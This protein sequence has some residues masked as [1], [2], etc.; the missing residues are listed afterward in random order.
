MRRNFL[1][2]IVLLF[3][4]LTGCSSTNLNELDETLSA[5]TNPFPPSHRSPIV[6]ATIVKTEAVKPTIKPSPTPTPVPTSSLGVDVS[7]L[8]GQQVQFWHPWQGEMEAAI[9]ELVEEFN[10][11][12]EWGIQVQVHSTG[13]LDKLDADLQVAIQE[14]KQPDL[15]VAYL[16]QALGWAETPIDLDVYLNDSDWGLSK[17]D[18]TDFFSVFWEHARQ[19]EQMLGLPAFASAQVLYYNQ[20]WAQELGFDSPPDTIEELE[21]QVCA[22]AKANLQDED[23]EN[24]GSGGLLLTSNYS[25]ML[26]WMTAFGAQITRDVSSKEDSPYQFNSPEV[27]NAFT[28]LRDLHDQGC[29]SLIEE[30]DP[31][32]LFAARS[33][34]LI[35][36]SVASMA[37]QIAAMKRSNNADN[38]T[39]LPFPSPDQQAV[40]PVYGPSLVLLQS[41]PSEQLAAWLFLR[42]LLT[43]ENQA[44][45]AQAS[46]GLPLRAASLPLLQAYQES[47]LQWAAA[48]E[49]LPLAQPEPAEYSWRLIRWAVSDAATQLF[50]S[51]FTI[52]QTA[53]LAKF[54]NTTATDLHSEMR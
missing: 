40:L 42:F 3:L 47:F 44:R 39:A 41:K 13:S 22:A 37:D 19:G 1:Y 53:D 17:S 25:A 31:Q 10:N 24:D 30:G 8:N 49:A 54:L 46:G 21:K 43:P 48:V 18:Q 2:S 23:T 7:S 51:Y 15:A 16:Y 27:V 36:G 14:S 20:S 12:N 11:Q 29:A 5:R 35:E 28:F 32:E 45:L 52:D 38:W 33:A 4:V 9:Q 26:G 34:L 50:R 6:T